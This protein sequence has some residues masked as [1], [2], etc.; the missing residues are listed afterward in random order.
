MCKR[1]FIVDLRIVGV[2]KGER[3]G[4][5]DVRQITDLGRGLG[6]RK[7]PSTPALLCAGVELYV[8]YRMIAP[9]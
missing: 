7:V 1:V 8:G 4:I 3:I 2:T 6:V 5:G 9:S